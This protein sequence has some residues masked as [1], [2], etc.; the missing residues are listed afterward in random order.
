MKLIYS[1]AYIKNA[2]AFFTLHKSLY[3]NGINYT[4]IQ[5]NVL[6]DGT[7]W[8]CGIADRKGNKIHF[9][10]IATVVFNVDGSTTAVV[11]KWAC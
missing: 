6:D 5:S 1:K 7:L 10:M 4:V 9:K 11:N 2:K 8:Y 3:V